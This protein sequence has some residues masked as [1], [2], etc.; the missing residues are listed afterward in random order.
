MGAYLRIAGLISVLLIFFLGGDTPQGLAMPVAQPFQENRVWVH[1]MPQLPSYNPDPTTPFYGALYPLRLGYSSPRNIDEIVLMQASGVNAVQLLEFP[2]EDNTGVLNSW[3]SAADQHPGFAVA[4]CITQETEDQAVNMVETYAS[5]AANYKSAAKEN[6]KLVIFTYG[7]RYGKTPDFWVNVRQRL[8]SENIDTYFI[9]DIGANLAVEGGLKPNL[10]VPYFPVFDA[11]YTFDDYLAG[12]FNDV[13][14]LFKYYNQLYAGGIMPGYDRTTPG[15]GYVDA[16]ATQVYRS[17]WEASLAAGLHVQTINTWNDYTEHTMIRP[18]SDWN[19]TLADITSFYSTKLRNVP[20]L[21]QSSKLYITTPQATYLGETPLVE[22][23]ILNLSSSEMT[24]KLKLFDGKG[25]SYGK[26]LSVV[27]PA[28]YAGAVSNLNNWIINSFPAQH[29]LRAK[30]E[31][32]NSAGKLVQQVTSAPILVYVPKDLAAPDP[33]RILY[34]SIPAARA[35]PGTVQLSLTG[36]ASSSGGNA[37][38]TVTPPAG[39]KVRFAE[40]LQNTVQVK[41]MFDQAP[42][43]TPVQLTNGFYVA[44]VIDEQE[45]V[46]Y[47]DPKEMSARN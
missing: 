16:Q 33:Q 21:N 42:Y 24:L 15:G 6:G 8:Q 44:R 40:V 31:M 2:Y 30:A 29:F 10:V 14:L 25:K 26:V 47:S 41:N 28:Y 7:A 18:S 17:Q 46:G 36:N 39:T 38:A 27:V 43:T 12:Y 45:R 4:P 32:Y 22:G 9:N 37:K 20:F 34:Y 19:W 1:Y 13:D 3:F 5:I 11:S 35:L 23:L